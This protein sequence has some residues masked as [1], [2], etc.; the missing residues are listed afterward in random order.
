MAVAGIARGDGLS[1]ML[2]DES[3]AAVEAQYDHLEQ[4]A[5]R[6][7]SQAVAGA[8]RQRRVRQLTP[9]VLAECLR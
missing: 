2:D 8:R 4:A 1:L 7:E 5:G 9:K 6:V 3:V